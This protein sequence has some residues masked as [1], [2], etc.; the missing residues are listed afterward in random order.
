MM[1]MMSDDDDDDDCNGDDGN[2]HVDQ[3]MQREPCLYC[4]TTVML[5]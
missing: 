1:V 2:R 3:Q 5:S 4:N